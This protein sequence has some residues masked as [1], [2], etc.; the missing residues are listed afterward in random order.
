VLSNFCIGGESKHS[1]SVFVPLISS[2][3][4]HAWNEEATPLARFFQL[5]ALWNHA[6]PT[7]KGSGAVR[8]I[9]NFFM[10]LTL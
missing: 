3:S 7:M 10:V 4:L 2:P 5:E 6:V 9:A 8:G 1:N